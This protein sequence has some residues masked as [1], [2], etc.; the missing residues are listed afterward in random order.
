MAVF[1]RLLEDQLT[2][3]NRKPSL[4]IV[5]LGTGSGRVLIGLQDAMWK[6]GETKFE[7]WGLE[8]S[9]A[10]LERAKRFWAEGVIKYQS[11]GFWEKINVEDHWVQCGATNF[12]D[13]IAPRDHGVDLIIFAAGGLGHIAS[14]AELLQFLRNVKQVLHPSGK[15]VISVLSDFILDGQGVGS[16]TSEHAVKQPSA[17]NAPL[18]VTKMGQKPLRIPSVDR[19]GLVYVKHPTVERMSG[20]IKSETFKLDVE[21]EGGNVLRSHDLSW[22]ER[23]FDPK[24][25]ES[26]VVK[27]GLRITCLDKGQIQVWYFLEHQN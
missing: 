13:H 4:S 2:K 3:V 9:S 8:P 14:D 16:N 17:S 11:M 20:Q 6:H 21:D 10:M 23:M 1:E 19:P 12:A 15:A 27:S 24:I 7:V 22:D 26:A 25:W 5:D 18:S